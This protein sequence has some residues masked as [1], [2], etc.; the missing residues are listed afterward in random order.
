VTGTDGMLY[1]TTEEGGTRNAGTVYKIDTTDHRYQVLHNFGTYQDGT[2]PCS[3]VRSSNGTLFGIT[4][5]GG[6]YDYGTVFRI[7]QDGTGYTVLRS[8]NGKYRR[9]RLDGY[10]PQAI[11]VGRNG[12]LYGTTDFGG[13]NGSGVIFSMEADG[14]DYTVLHSFLTKPDSS[15][16]PCKLLGDDGFFYGIANETWEGSLFRIKTDGTCYSTLFEFCDAGD[17]AGSPAGLQIL[18]DESFIGVVS[19]GR[20]G[21]GAVFK[22]NKNAT[23]FYGLHY[24]GDEGDGHPL[25]PNA[26]L[27]EGID[28]NVY[29]TTQNGGSFGSG[30][31]GGGTV[32]T[33]TKDGSS[34]GFWDLGGEEGVVPLAGLAIGSN[35]VCYGTTSSAGAHGRGTIFTLVHSQVPYLC[36][37]N[38]GT[39]TIEKYIGPGCA[40]NIP[41]SINGVPVS[42]I[43][44]SAFADSVSLSSVTIPDSVTSIGDSAFF[45][46]PNLSRVT[47]G[48]GVTNIGEAVFGA[49]D[50]L[51]LVIIGSNVAHIATDAF[52]Y[53]VGLTSI[54][55]LGNAP[56]LGSY[57]FYGVKN[58][59]VYYL[60]GT[61]GWGSAFGGLPTAMATKNGIPVSWLQG[62]GLPSDGSA[63]HQP[64][65][66]GGGF[67]AWQQWRAGTNPN[68]LSDDLRM[69]DLS[70]S[71]LQG[72]STRWRSVS[73]RT[74]TVWRS[75]GLLN[76][77]PF[78]VLKKHVQ[79]LDGFTE[80]IDQTTFGATQC[81]YRVTVE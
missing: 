25:N 45:G 63:D 71:G 36:S 56:S 14:S 39:L 50:T 1:G 26:E 42:R 19:G 29:G 80:Y 37:T 12:L 78:L 33:I 70:V 79:G 68:D 59:T 32:F 48:N 74:Y 23:A 54:Y 24:F 38:N 5:S 11:I 18:S 69:T 65:P 77:P 35:G 3:L 20:D 8:F 4:S 73:N 58:A 76:K 10:S 6:E 15:R 28:G 44:D 52:A 60:A 46:C 40:V 16:K 31:Y 13:N 62:Y 67:T 9:D 34:C 61:T 55:F 81:F 17:A 47:I 64:S 43:N 66:D 72:P 27:V 2:Y 7:E 75:T 57:A 49:C 22:L 53:C 30:T 41:S 51:A 21:N